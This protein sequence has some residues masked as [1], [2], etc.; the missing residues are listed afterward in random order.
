MEDCK[1]C[2]NSSHKTYSNVAFNISP[3]F[4]T[5]HINSKHMFEGGFPF[6]EF[7][8]CK[9]HIWLANA[10]ESSFEENEIWINFKVPIYCLHKII[11]FLIIT[12]TAENLKLLWFQTCHTSFPWLYFILLFYLIAQQT[13][14]FPFLKWKLIVAHEGGRDCWVRA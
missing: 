10:F 14:G 11:S 4:V 6:T 9:R 2:K 1:V 12:K 7:Q 5:Q 8:S 3:L 13:L